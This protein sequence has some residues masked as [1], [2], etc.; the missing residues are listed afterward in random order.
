M[1]RFVSNGLYLKGLVAKT[2]VG[3]SNKF[4]LIYFAKVLSDKVDFPIPVTD[5]K[6]MLLIPPLIT[7]RQGW[8]KGYYKTV[9]QCEMDDS[10][11]LPSHC[12]EGNQ[13][14]TYFNEFDE[15][16]E[17]RVEPCGIGGMWGL[18]EIADN[19]K[20]ATER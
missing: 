12:F 20:V 6:E 5:F 9:E 13:P 11:L 14:R 2:R 7:N 16:L 15:R 4:L 10:A 1:Q 17:R 19:L 18:L 3:Y 8:L